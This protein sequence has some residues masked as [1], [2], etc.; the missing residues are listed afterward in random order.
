MRR[1]I[2]LLLL[3]LGRAAGA[4]AA[5][6]PPPPTVHASVDQTALWIGDRVTYTVAIDC[7]RDV[8]ILLDDMAKEKLRLNGLEIVGSDSTDS[9][10]AADRTLHRFRY[11]LTTYRFD[12]PAPSIEPFSVRYYA[13]RPGQRLTD[14]APAGEVSIPGAVL[15][16]RSMLPDAQPTYDIR[17]TQ[18]P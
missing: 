3:G 5:P 13:R 15:A 6:A 18:D 17:A 11:V 12:A 7:G 10:D 14:A 16:F 9:T 2:L 1:T 8:D 4:A